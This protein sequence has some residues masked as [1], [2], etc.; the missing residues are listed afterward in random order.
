MPVR[1][2]LPKDFSLASAAHEHPDQTVRVW[3]A[4]AGKS[5]QSWRLG[6]DD[7]TVSIPDHQVGIVWPS[8]RSDDLVISL[9]LSGDLNYLAPN[10]PKP[11]RSLHGHQR[12][13]TALTS[14]ST[15]SASTFWTGDAGGRMCAWPVNSGAAESLDGAEHATYVSGLA[16]S[17]DG[18]AIA[19]VGWDDTLR[20]VD[21]TARTFTGS[22]QPTDGQPRVVAASGGRTVIATHKGIQAFRGDKEVYFLWTDYAPTCAAVHGDL[23]VVGGDDAVL[24][25]YSLSADD[26]FTRKSTTPRPGAHA[27]T[28]AFSPDG[29]SLAAGFADGKILVYDT[30]AAGEWPVANSRW[31]AHTARVTGIAWRADGRYV[32]SGALDTGVF[33]WSV[34]DP[35]KRIRAMNAHKEGVN[36]VC[37]EGDKRVV[38]VGMDAAVKVWNVEGLT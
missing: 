19:S 31:S 14:S 25:V 8:G 12:N 37:W 9:S 26:K 15:K 21:T 35:G 6:D 32:A 16:A 20:A 34:E 13:V 4:E 36:G 10:T 2:L 17:A 1:E 22:P 28:L 33:V 18:A 30:S 29:A 3:D 5:I 23:V 7:T 11:R 24:H 27:S 38:S